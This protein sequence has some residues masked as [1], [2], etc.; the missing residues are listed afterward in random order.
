M[1]PTESTILTQFLLSPAPLPSTVSLSKFT[2]FFPSSQASN[3]QIRL[4]YRDLQHQRALL[5]DA[6]AHN[7]S[8]EVRRGNAQR[9]AVIKARKES[10]EG[11][12]DE[13]VSIEKAVSFCGLEDLG[14]RKIERTELTDDSFLDKLPTSRHINR[15]LQKAY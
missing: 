10:T 8:N 14:E 3:P 12:E 6:V 15:I 4:L 7:I 11:E 5:A 9:R 1:A 2:G 13:E